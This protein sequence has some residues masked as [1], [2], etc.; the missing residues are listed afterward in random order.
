LPS[1]HFL[2]KRI[3]YTISHISSRSANDNFCTDQ[4]AE[5]CVAD[6]FG[7]LAAR[8]ARLSKVTKFSVQQSL[9][10]VQAQWKDN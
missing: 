3:Y 6:V 5:E 9:E 7:D 4:L 10:L 1:V 2:N 8:S